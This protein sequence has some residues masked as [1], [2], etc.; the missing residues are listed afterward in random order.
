MFADEVSIE[1]GLLT[2]WRSGDALDRPSVGS[3][4][5]A[6]RGEARPTPDARPAGRSARTETHGVDVL[7]GRRRAPAPI[8]PL[9]VITSIDPV[10]ISDDLTEIL[11]L[12]LHTLRRP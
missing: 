9:P 8:P 11:A 3:A 4:R 7:A 1:P 12:A 6:A 10:P 2:Q 5:A